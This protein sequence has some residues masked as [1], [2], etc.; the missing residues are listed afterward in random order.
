MHKNIEKIKKKLKSKFYYNYEIYKHTWFKT[1]GNAYIFCLVYDEKELEIILNNIGDLQY[2]IIG[3][4]SNVLIRDKGFRGIIFKLGKLFNQISIHDNFINVGAGILDVNFSKFAQMNSIKNLEFYS[5]IPGTIGGAIKM[6]AGCYGSETKRVLKNIKTINHK[7]KVNFLNNNQL[8]LKYRESSLSDN[9]IVISAQYK[10]EYGAKEEI[11]KNIFDIKLKRE[12][13]Q[14]LRTKTGGST[15]KNPKNNYAANL[16]EMAGC[17]KLN[18]GDA[19]VSA[20]HANFL[21]NTNKASAEDIEE[22]GLRIIDKVFDKF[23]IKLEWEI[24][25]LGA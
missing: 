18:V 12:Q 17:K 16:I 7:G 23:Q 14:P 6:N 4:G 20:K 9:D 3:A 24:K 10:L 15:F 22:L 2:Q 11:D 5:G 8:N 19:C 25:I 13:S 21:I 1:G